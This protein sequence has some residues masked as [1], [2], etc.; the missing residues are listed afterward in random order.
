M[1]VWFSLIL[2]ITQ[3]AREGCEREAFFSFLKP[4]QGYI[5]PL[6]SSTVY[7]DQH[8]QWFYFIERGVEGKVCSQNS[9][10]KKSQLIGQQQRNNSF[11]LRKVNANNNSHDSGNKIMLQRVTFSS[12]L[13]P[14]PPCPKDIFPSNG[15]RFGGFCI[16]VR[17]VMHVHS[18]T[19]LVKS[20]EFLLCS[21]C[22]AALVPDLLGYDVIRAETATSLNF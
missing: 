7:T 13:S 22:S 14:F 6:F 16:T 9:P 3:F 8:T 10:K 11:S 20:A 17:V 19:H 21:S 18:I 4:G 2:D 1:S 15:S 12:W 5:K